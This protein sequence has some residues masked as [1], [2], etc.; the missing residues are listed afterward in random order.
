[1]PTTEPVGRRLTGAAKVV[2]RR[3][4]EIFGNTDRLHRASPSTGAVRAARCRCPGSAP[5][6]HR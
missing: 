2:P 3:A 5:P 6:S 4:E 1:M